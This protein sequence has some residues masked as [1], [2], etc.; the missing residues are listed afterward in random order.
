MF[1]QFAIFAICCSTFFMQTCCAYTESQ[2][3]SRINWLTNFDDAVNQSKASSKPLVLF[4]TGSDWCS[5]C[6]RLEDEV[7]N[8][9]EF[10][11]AIGNK[12]IFVK[13]DA[14]LYTAQDPNL[15][16]QIKQL[17][18][19]FGVR[20][21]PTILLFDAKNNQQIGSTGYRPGG[22]KSFADYLL[23]M[24][25]DYSSYKQK[26][27]ALDQTS[28]SASDLKQLYAKAK[29]L[30]LNNDA[31]E[32][33]KVGINSDSPL[34]FQMEHYRLLADEGHV[35]SNEAEGL[36]HRLLSA[37]P[38]NEQGIPYQLAVIDFETSFADIE[39]ENYVPELAIAPLI[40]YMEKFG[41]Q[42]KDKL[43][44]L[45]MIVSQVYLDSNQML[46]ALKYAQASYECAP[47]TVQPEIARAI[48]NIRSQIHSLATTKN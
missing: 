8:T 17:Q 29:E 46:N 20:S 32:I 42:D 26:M 22:G 7:L 39:K 35:H 37:D 9:P 38:E 23:K 6:K 28:F 45:Q 43:W 36:K 25:N 15:K 14:P 47:S 24:T 16:A 2:D 33:V 27:G 31:L 13:L 10:S 12:F 21:F 1:Y 11:A 4:F 30:R 5:W 41:G 19:R 48:Q 44:R 18:Q 40:T 34:Y 3:R